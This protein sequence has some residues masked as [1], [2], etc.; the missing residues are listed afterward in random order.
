M[1]RA[2]EDSPTRCQH[3][4]PTK[5]QCLNEAEPDVKFCAAHGGKAHQKSLRDKQ[6]KQYMLRKWNARK[7]EFSDHSDLKSLKE[8]IG[9]LR[10][11]IE[12]KL[13]LCHTELDLMA[14]AGPVSDL[15]MKVEKLVSSSIRMEEKLGRMLDQTQAMTLIDEIIEIIADHV[16]ESTMGEIADQIA[17]RLPE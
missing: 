8:E 16:D 6:T 7:D 4:I 3:V 14:H 5:G 17:E 2:E 13:N 11:F 10:M 9:I 12:N 15:I 1:K